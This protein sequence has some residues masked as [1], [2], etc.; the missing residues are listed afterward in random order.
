MSGSRVRCSPSMQT[1][2]ALRVDGGQRETTQRREVWL[3]SATSLPRGHPP[4]PSRPRAF[5]W[6]EEE[7]RT[8]AKAEMYKE[9][10]AVAQLQLLPSSRAVRQPSSPPV[11]C[12]LLACATSARLCETR[13]P[14]VL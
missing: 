13:W 3:R 14:A 7:W 4:R 5:G 1:V 11:R 12:G 6:E 8:E 9:E 10:V 2:R